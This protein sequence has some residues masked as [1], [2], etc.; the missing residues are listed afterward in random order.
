MTDRGVPPALRGPSD[1][2]RIRPLLSLAVAGALGL[3]GLATPAALAAEG[4]WRAEAAPGYVPEGLLMTS[5]PTTSRVRIIDPAQG[6]VVFDFKAMSP[7]GTRVGCANH[8]AVCQPMGVRHTSHRG[9]DLITLAV[10]HVQ[11]T[12]G[13]P[14]TSFPAVI[15]RFEPTVPIRPVFTLASLDFRGVP[16]GDAYC[17]QGEAE[18]HGD[19]LVPGCSLQFVHTFQIVDDRPDDERVSFVVTDAFNQRIL[20]V[21]LDYAGGNTVGEVEWVLGALN[22]DWPLQ[23]WPN[24]SQ[25]IGDEPGGP[26]LLVTFFALDTLDETAGQLAM[27]RLDGDEWQ[28][29]WRFPD[30]ASGPKPYLHAAHMGELVTDPVTGERYI[31]YSHGR[32]M[33]DTWGGEANAD[34][35]GSFGLLAPGAR[36]GDPPTYLLEAVLF[37][38]DPDREVLY[39]RD[40]DFMPD[41][42]LLFSDA[43]CESLCPEDAAVYHIPPIHRGAAPSPLAGYFSPDHSQQALYLVPTADVL[44]TF[45]CGWEL[46][47]ETQWI[48]AADLG[49]TLRRAARRPLRSCEGR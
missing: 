45:T 32:G 47:F 31:W 36:L 33:S 37:S 10:T 30:P 29:A 44:D 1:R 43:A 16:G 28:A 26:F 35:G 38:D 25:Y 17:A 46:M 9:V 2:L 19:P 22:P 34:R 49:R 7:D 3:V 42:S 27:Y 13:D 21:T 40:V 8:P 14:A 11:P 18:S 12:T 20:R 41:G 23:G 24:A 4:G 39:A 5:D 15:S 48:P 6:A